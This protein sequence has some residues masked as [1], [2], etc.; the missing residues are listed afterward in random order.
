M[1]VDA[2]NGDGHIDGDGGG[3]DGGEET[4]DQR[5]AT[6]EFREGGDVAEPGGHSEVGDEEGKGVEGAGMDDLFPSVEEHDGAE[7]EASA[8]GD[9]GAKFLNTND[10]MRTPY[11]AQFTVRGKFG[12]W[13]WVGIG[14]FLINGGLG[15]RDFL[16]AECFSLDFH[17]KS[18]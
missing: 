6:E 16:R 3:G 12:G 8:E 15:W 17:R 7:N 10:Q 2:Q 4:K 9:K 11:L 14:I 5:G 1:Q 18:P 13:I